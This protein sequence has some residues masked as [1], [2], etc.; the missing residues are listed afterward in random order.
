M[1]INI[2]NGNGLTLAQSSKVGSVKSGEGVVAGMV[3]SFNTSDEVLSA[4]SAT[5]L[6]GFALNSQTDSDVIGS[7]K[8]GVLLLDGAS[9]I[10]TDQTDEDINATNY[11]TGTAVYGDAAGAVTTDNGVAK[12]V[13]TVVGIRSLPTTVTVGSTKV[14][15]FKNFLGIKLAA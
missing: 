4:S 8:I 14:Q 2:K 5:A 9:V 3:V 13:G 11:P 15:G 6:V 12:I 10:E 7:G 1:A